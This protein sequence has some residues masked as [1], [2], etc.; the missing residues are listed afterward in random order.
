[1]ITENLSTLK[2]HKLTQEQYD[3][4]LAAGNIDANALYLTPDE[5][6]MNKFNFYSALNQFS[7]LTN[8]DATLVAMA[9]A[10]PDFSVLELIVWKSNLP[11]FTFPAGVG[12]YLLLTIK[13][14]QASYI[15]VELRDLVNNKIF[16]CSK[17]GG[18]WKDWDRVIMAS[19][20]TLSGT[21]LTLNWL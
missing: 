8:A 9:D 21:T 4:E 14:G 10:M 17:Y 7:S 6:V 15:D 13:K 12:N 20:F 2:I 11:S 16:I 5:E 19:D 3:R 18:V 1:M